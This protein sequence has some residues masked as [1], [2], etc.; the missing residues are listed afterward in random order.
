MPQII[1]GGRP[2]AS[3]DGDILND[4]F[5]GE[6]YV[7]LD[8]RPSEVARKSL[9]QDSL[10]VNR[11]TANAGEYLGI[12]NDAF[13]SDGENSSN[14]QASLGRSQRKGIFFKSMRKAVSRA[15]VNKDSPKPYDASLK[16]QHEKQTATRPVDRDPSKVWTPDLKHL[17]SSTKSNG[18]D[19]SDNDNMSTSRPLITESNA[20][21]IVPKWKK[22]PGTIG[23]Y[24]HGNSCFMNCVLQC[25]SN[26]DSFTEYFIR[27][28]YKNDLKNSSNGKKGVFRS[29]Q[30]EVTEQLGIL[31][32]SLWSGKYTSE[33][34]KEFKAVVGKYN[35]Q[36]KGDHQHD[37]QEFLLWLLDRVHED[38]ST[39]SRKKVKPQKTPVLKSDEELAAEAAAVNGES[40]IL[41]LS[42]FDPYLCVSLPLPQKCPRTVYVV[43]VSSASHYF[44][45]VK[46]AITL[47][48]YDGVKEL[49]ERV[50]SEAK[51]PS[52]QLLL[53]QLK[54]DGFGSTYSDEEPISD[55]P[56]NELVYAIETYSEDA[57]L[58]S[59]LQEFETPTCQLLVVHTEVQS[60]AARSHRFGSPAVL[61]VRRDITWKNLQKE[62]LLKME[63]CVCEEILSQTQKLSNLFMLRICDGTTRKNYLPSDVDLPLY[64]QSAERAYTCL[65]EDFGPPH[66]K[67][68]A[69]WDQ[70]TKKTVI[71]D[72]KEHIETHP[73]VAE[74]QNNT[75]S[76]V[77]VSL[78]ECFRLYTQ[79]EKL[80]GDD[81]WLC[82]HCKQ[83]QQGTIKTLK[84]WSLPDVLILH[85]KRFK[86]SGSSRSK[87]NT[88]VEFPVENL[89]MSAHLTHRNQTHPL[90]RDDYCY[91]LLGVSN[92]YGNMA[93]GH[94]TSY[95]RSSIDG[96]WRE[97]NDTKVRTLEGPV[98]TKEAYLLFYQR[99]ALSK[100][101]NQ[102]IF[103]G[104][105]WVF[106]LSFAPSEA[107]EEKPATSETWSADIN[108]HPRRSR[109]RSASPSAH[110][111][112]DKDVASFAN[113]RIPNRPLTPQPF[114]RPT[115]T[116]T[117][118]KNDDDDDDDSE[119]DSSDVTTPSSPEKNS[120]LTRRSRPV[121]RQASAPGFQFRREKSAGAP[122]SVKF[123]DSLY[124]RRSA[125]TDQIFPADENKPILKPEISNG[126]SRSQSQSGPKT[127][128]PPPTQAIVIRHEPPKVPVNDLS[129]ATSKTISHQAYLT[130]S[131]LDSD[132]KYPSYSGDYNRYLDSK[133]TSKSLLSHEP[134]SILQ[135]KYDSKDSYPSHGL[136]SY[137]DAHSDA[138]GARKKLA[139]LII[140]PDSM[141]RAYADRTGGGTDSGDVNCGF[142]RNGSR[143]Y[144]KQKSSELVR[145]QQDRYSDVSIPET[146]SVAHSY[147]LDNLCSDIRGR[148]G[149]F[150]RDRWYSSSSHFGNRRAGYARLEEVDDYFV[151]LEEPTDFPHLSDFR[152]K[153]PG[154]AFRKLADKHFGD[155]D[156]SRDNYLSRLTDGYVSPHLNGDINRLSKYTNV[157]RTSDLPPTGRHDRDIIPRS[158]TDHSIHYNSSLAPPP[159]PTPP[160]SI[161]EEQRFSSAA[162]SSSLP[163]S[164]GGYL[165]TGRISSR[166]I[167]S[168]QSYEFAGRHVGTQEVLIPT[169]IQTL[170]GYSQSM[171]ESKYRFRRPRGTWGI[172]PPKPATNSLESMATPCLR[173]SSV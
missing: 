9:P 148:D 153:V 84:L 110:R 40:F 159:S 120:N 114:R 42:T 130:N 56:E 128:R 61:R 66:I 72:D 71:V 97:F 1:P 104:D 111:Q 33:V 142:V 115:L 162:I 116:F 75:P 52:K 67:I 81:A 88:L 158:N 65:D 59:S 124:N 99:R 173:E 79:E 35:S 109:S 86:L 16:K 43:V 77:T 63:G 163:S 14:S 92:H 27:D 6:L 32:K 38:V 82:P 58:Q 36:Y 102:R 133:K 17:G 23:I 154:E 49:R 73:S 156:R 15:F 103:T 123:R 21:P 171:R 20:G 78:D 144:D 100:E 108:N 145:F 164:S 113:R 146:S 93:G 91:D 106:T 60:G 13:D 18:L 151:D 90:K 150:M 157:S 95:C 119:D 76:Q 168:I 57:S 132:A 152:T 160:H 8:E 29:N 80:I 51:I 74:A 53:V 54:E 7:N 167:S 87:L 24:N 94:Y 107:V 165:T 45:E 70:Q 131:S 96:E 39:C 28:F 126:V 147:Q 62:I 139:Q 47:N 121:Q 48:Q 166:E 172:K 137:R 64:T 140:K 12:C 85:L 134:A 83:Q 143:M 55:I 11:G 135:V 34:S 41:K 101:I 19:A 112:T 25:L 44:H 69:E 50:S 127:D 125:E 3:S 138:D 170:P 149:E 155:G 37:A 117:D 30:G 129:L 89:D 118:D 98:A 161:Q 141:N 169:G 22:T 31:L 10:I 4:S 105:H 122:F 46:M 26:T 5:C 68:V 136:K 2:R